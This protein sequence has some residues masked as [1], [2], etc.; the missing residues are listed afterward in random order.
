MQLQAFTASSMPSGP[1][2]PQQMV[3]PTTQGHRNTSS[4][5]YRC[6]CTAV[7]HSGASHLALD[8]AYHVMTPPP[9]GKFTAQDPKRAVVCRCCSRTHR[10]RSRRPQRLQAW[11]ATWP[12]RTAASCT[13][14][15]RLR[16]P[17]PPSSRHSQVSRPCDPGPLRWLRCHTPQ[18]GPLVVVDSFGTTTLSHPERGFAPNDSMPSAEP[19]YPCVSPPWRTAAG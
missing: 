7:G 2:T 16:W 1:D 8:S 17:A 5:A 11:S 6:A 19:V 13:W 10:G 9:A 3:P 12:A 4:W 14:Q 18:I 15:T